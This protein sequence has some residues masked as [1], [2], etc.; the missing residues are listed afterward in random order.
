MRHLRHF[1]F[2]LYHWLYHRKLVKFWYTSDFSPRCQLEGMN[3]IGRRTRFSGSLGYGSTMGDDCLLNGEIGRFCSIGH[4]CTYTN[5]THPIKAPFVTSSSLFYSISGQ[6]F[7]MGRSFAQEQLFDEFLFLDAKRGLVNRI[8]S[9]VWLGH[10]VNLIGGIEIADG[11]VVLSRAVVTK[12]VPPYAIVG[13]IPAK[14]IGY[15]Y[16]PETIEFLLRVKWWDRSPEWL[17]QNWR[18]LT[19]I[20]A[21]KQYF[22]SE[23]NLQTETSC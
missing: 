13:G 11:A 8:G 21:F 15:R 12:D 14:V 19:D 18:L 17:K 22:S 20:E 23:A 2:F 4:R 10:E 16:D 3:M 5:A 7:P 9:D 1:L 6:K